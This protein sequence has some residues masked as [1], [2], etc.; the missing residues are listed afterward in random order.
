MSILVKFC[1]FIASLLVILTQNS[2]LVFLKSDIKSKKDKNQ[3]NFIATLKFDFFKFVL[4]LLFKSEELNQ[5]SRK[6]MKAK[7]KED[8]KPRLLKQINV[9]TEFKE[10]WLSHRSNIKKQ[11]K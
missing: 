11:L 1:Q 8:K 4:S 5:F 7:C 10:C 3:Q 2:K 9:I 6:K